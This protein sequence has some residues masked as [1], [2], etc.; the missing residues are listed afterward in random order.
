MLFSIFCVDGRKKENYNEAVNFEGKEV[1]FLMKRNYGIDLL[2]CVSMFMVAMLH[3]LGH[4]GVLDN[5]LPGSLSYGTAWFLETA[6]YCAVNCYALI[7]GYVGIK[8]KYRYS[9]IIM[10]WLQV[11]F[12]TVLITALF[13]ILNPD[14][15]GIKEIIT[16]VLPVTRYTYW[17]FTAYFGLFILMP[18]LNA[19][20]NAL[21]EKQAYK[22]VLLLVAVFS[23]LKTVSSVL[24][25]ADIFSLNGGYA[26]M[27]LCIVYIIG[28]CIGKHD[29]LKRIKS[30]YLF[31]GYIVCVGFSLMFKLAVERLGIGL[32]ANLFINYVSPTILLSAVCLLGLFSRIK[33]NET[34][35]KIIGFFAPAAFSVYLIHEHPLIRES[36]MRNRFVFLADKNP[37]VII[38]VVICAAAAIFILC[39]LIDR[40]RIAIFKWIKIKD[41]VSKIDK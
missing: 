5:A 39:A 9:S 8:A 23:V 36:L 2:R 38:G 30:I 34:A 17:Y 41:L 29:M 19:G 31:I 15:V 13:L 37:L 40:L 25:Y 35:E 18:I 20:I 4:G 24:C 27:W 28:G 14:S 32:N 7:S 6:A 22:T 3:I 21:S 1:V 10:L 33:A 16:A 12:Y 11:V 26:V